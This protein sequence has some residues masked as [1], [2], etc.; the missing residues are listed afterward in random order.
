MFINNLAIIIHM[1][2]S[3]H[4]FRL[5]NNRGRERTKKMVYVCALRSN[6]FPFFE[7]TLKLVNEQKKRFSHHWSMTTQFS[8]HFIFNLFFSIFFH[9]PHFIHFGQF[10]IK[11]P[12]NNYSDCFLTNI[13]HSRHLKWSLT[14]ATGIKSINRI[15]W[16]SSLFIFFQLFC[17]KT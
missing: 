16:V 7:A 14:A 9:S 2:W 15:L 4:A 17:S 10:Q 3:V 13:F 8:S 11:M 1:G 5:I 12:L 6:N